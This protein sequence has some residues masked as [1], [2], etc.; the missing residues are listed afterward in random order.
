MKAQWESG[1]LIV[2][3][4]EES[5]EKAPIVYSQRPRKHVGEIWDGWGFN[6]K[7]EKTR[8]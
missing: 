3:L 4:P 6:P 7:E 5:C 1:R 8:V 2:K